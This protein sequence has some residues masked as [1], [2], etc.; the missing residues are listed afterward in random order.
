MNARTEYLMPFRKLEPPSQEF[1]TAYVNPGKWLNISWLLDG[2]EVKSILM[3]LGFAFYLLLGFG[4]VAGEL[5]ALEG[6][7]LHC[8]LKSAGVTTTV[9][10]RST[11]NVMK[12]HGVRLIKTVEDESFML[13]KGR[14]QKVRP[15]RKT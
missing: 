15:L 14:W 5:E 10:S 11:R 12:Y 1:M 3:T 13:Y 4:I 6:K 7:C 9:A 8:R 2:I